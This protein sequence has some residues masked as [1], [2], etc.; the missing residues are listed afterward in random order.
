[1]VYTEIKERNRI[2]YYYRV[3]SVRKGKKISKKRKYLGV[4]LSKENLIIKEKGADIQLN[5]K[6]V[7]KKSREINKITP[8]IIKILKKNN[9]KRA[10]IFGSY[11]R[12][13]QKKD[14]DIDILIEPPK[15][16]G[17]GFVGIQLELQN[18]LKKDVDLLSYNG[19][20][21]ALKK[22]ILNDEVRI[23]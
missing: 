10:G 23:I 13:E 17:F 3:V 5:L 19:I 18:K 12:G 4:N 2:K 21:H 6:K 22:S 16:I 14:S 9:V 11:A 8:I 1:M 15:G 7:E 20:H